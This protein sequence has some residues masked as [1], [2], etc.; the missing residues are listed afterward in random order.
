MHSAARRGSGAAAGHDGVDYDRRYVP[1]AL[2]T[3]P[4][5]HDRRMCLRAGQWAMAEH[6]ISRAHR[7]MGHV[8][9][10]AVIRGHL[11]SARGRSTDARRC[12]RPGLD[13]YDVPVSSTAFTNAWLIGASSRRKAVAAAGAR[14]IVCFVTAGSDSPAVGDAH[15]PVMGKARS[16]AT[17]RGGDRRGSLHSL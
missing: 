11:G 2:I 13:G 7:R 1:R 5:E 10:V 9:D 12:L 15:A 3:M 16:F 6:A 14:G 17:S 8:A 4:A